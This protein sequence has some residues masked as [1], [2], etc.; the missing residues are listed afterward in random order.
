M[1][2]STA[3][4]FSGGGNG[5]RY[6]R[7]WRVAEGQSRFWEPSNNR[8]IMDT[9]ASGIDL[10]IWLFPIK[11][12]AAVALYL[13]KSLESIWGET[14]SHL[15]LSPHRKHAALLSEDRDGQG[16]PIGRSPAKKKSCLSY[17]RAKQW[18]TDSAIHFPMP[19]FGD[20]EDSQQNKKQIRML[21]KVIRQTDSG[22]FPSGNKINKWRQCKDKF[23]SVHGI[24]LHAEYNRVSFAERDR[25]LKKV[26]SVVSWWDS[27][28][29][30]G[31]SAPGRSTGARGFQKSSRWELPDS[32]MPAKCTVYELFFASSL[33]LE[34]L[35]PSMS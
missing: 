17:L 19:L 23:A 29:G 2:T 26:F 31:R 25:A 1:E 11:C 15:L 30:S 24:V 32:S 33:I 35:N 5:V 13:L 9:G 4:C 34:P 6:V 8:V 22:H 18:D 12:E 7:A 16:R 3:A 28:R 10:A 20:K 21:L 27:R 14:F